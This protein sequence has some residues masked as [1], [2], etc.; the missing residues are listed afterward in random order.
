MQ[1]ESNMDAYQ[2]CS[3]CPR[4][5][6]ID[7][8]AGKRGFCGTD[9]QLRVVRAALHYWV[10]PCI[11]ETEG[12]GAVFFSGCNLGCV[13]CQNYE[14]SHLTKEMTGITVS[15]Q[16]LAEIFFSLQEQQANNIN[17]VT[18]D[19][20]IPAVAEALRIAKTQGLSI[21]VIFNSSSYVTVGSLHM[22]EG[23]V[24]VYLPDFKFYSSSKAA[25]YLRAADYPQTARRAIEE[26]VRQT[27][28]CSFDENGR[29]QKGVIVRHLLMPHGLLEAKMIVK[30]LYHS[31]GDAVYLSLM[32]QYTPIMEHLKR[33][34]ELQKGPSEAEYT[35]L[36]EYAL[37]LGVKN[38]YMQEGGTVSESFIPA[39]DGTGV[40]SGEGT[41]V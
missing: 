10:E 4:A 25:K 38:A 9:A 3:L 12:S 37:A 22:L 7:R 30:E 8:S 15:P 33:Y 11:S 16:R 21:P 31:Y 40:E 35:D 17:L 13:F 6:G 5:C 1:A 32:N 24:D 26:M 2:S 41:Q 23:L 14:I 19:V 18:A 27:G 36:I 20:H 28:N 29:I 34:P 39:F